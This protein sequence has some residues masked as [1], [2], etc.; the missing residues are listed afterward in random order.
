MSTEYT[1]LTRNVSLDEETDKLVEKLNS[2]L[3]LKNYSAALRIIIRQW[4]ERG[5]EVAKLERKLQEQAITGH[6]LQAA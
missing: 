5:R 1:P 2:N 4:Q 3:G 6:G